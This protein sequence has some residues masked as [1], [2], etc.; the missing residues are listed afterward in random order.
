MLFDPLH[1]ERASPVFPS[2]ALALGWK[3]RFRRLL[4]VVEGEYF[5][6]K[7]GEKVLGLW[8]KIEMEV[9]FIFSVLEEEMVGG[10]E[11]GLPQSR[12]G[13]AGGVGE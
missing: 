13:E 1:Y 12:I 2:L 9:G 8:L 11:S 4:L 7:F 5:A 10:G 6:E 3:E